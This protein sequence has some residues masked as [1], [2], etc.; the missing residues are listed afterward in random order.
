MEVSQVDFKVLELLEREPYTP[1]ELGKILK[2]HHATAEKLLFKLSATNPDIRSKSIGRFVVYWK[3]PKEELE[4]YDRFIKE[5]FPGIPPKIQILM[6]LWRLKAVNP[7]AAIK[8]DKLS[9]GK[10]DKA[11]LD[12]LAGKQRIIIDSSRRTYLTELGASIAEGACKTYGKSG[13]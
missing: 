3:P 7:K 12:E 10:P 13:S 8:I 6:E 9:G 11:A 4:E 2:I 1:T 5:V